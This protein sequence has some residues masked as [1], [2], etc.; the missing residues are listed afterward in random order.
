M[1]E[2]WARIHPCKLLML[3]S[4]RKPSRK[5]L[6][7]FSDA[8]REYIDAYPAWTAK[9]AKKLVNGP[10][11][12]N[13]DKEILVGQRS[14][15]NNK[16]HWFIGP[17]FWR[18]SYYQNNRCIFAKSLLSIWGN[19]FRIK[20]MIT[21]QLGIVLDAQCLHI[22]IGKAFS[23]HIV[24]FVTSKG[25]RAE[26]WWNS[27]PLGTWSFTVMGIPEYLGF[28]PGNSRPYAWVINHHNHLI[29]I[30]WSSYNPSIILS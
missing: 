21:S 4:T 19:F 5:A 6:L 12:I 24:P 8:S 25:G 1:L 20:N 28:V 30:L 2:S 15:N 22:E 16:L 27:K 10:E 7:F 29:N 26:L 13:P 3:I 18:M 9:Y 17:D 11:Q 23:R 14:L